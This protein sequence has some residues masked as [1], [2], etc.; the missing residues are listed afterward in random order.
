MTAEHW[1]VES[2]HKLK[3]Y[4]S[5]LLLMI[6][7][8][9]SARKKLDSYCK[10]CLHDDLPLSSSWSIGHRP[11]QFSIDF[12][13]EQAF[14]PSSRCGPTSSFQ[15]PHP[16]SRSSFD[17][18]SSSCPKGSSGS[19]GCRVMLL[20]SFPKVWPI[21]TFSLTSES[22]L[23]PHLLFPTGSHSLSCL[24]SWFSKFV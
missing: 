11:V 16:F 14:L 2:L 6:K 5:V 12:C 7:T 8:S 21:H 13:P 3:F 1:T 24:S 4:P 20:A 23:A 9:Q 17:D 22:L 15:I 19:S 18:P 10:N